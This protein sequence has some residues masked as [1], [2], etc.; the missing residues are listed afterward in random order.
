MIGVNFVNYSCLGTWYPEL[1]RW[2]LAFRPNDLMMCNT[3]NGTERL[4]RDLKHD[5]LIGFKNCT[6]SE[7]ISVLI[8]TFL[9]KIFERYVEQNVRYT[10]G[11]KKYNVSIPSFLKNKPKVLVIDLLGKMDKVTSDMIDSVK[12]WTDNAFTVKSSDFTSNKSFIVDFGSDETFCSCS[13]PDYRRN[14]MLCKHFFA[15]IKSGMRTYEDITPLFRNSPFVCLDE[16]ILL[17]IG[18]QAGNIDEYGEFFNF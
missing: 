3:N 7:L 12:S 16:D 11:F 15:V 10:S 14:R 6:L 1:S 18:S 13:C 4:N 9:P 2:C 17:D 8:E 5:D